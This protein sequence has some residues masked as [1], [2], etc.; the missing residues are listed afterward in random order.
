M[1]AGGP[2]LFELLLWYVTFLFSVTLHEAAHAWAAMKGGDLTA[3]RGGQV[4]LDPTPHVRR[5]PFGM[6]ILPVASLLINGW[7]FGFASAPYDPYWAEAYPKRASLM[8][9]AG[10]LANWLLVLVSACFI[11]L[12]I[13][14]FGVFESPSTIS[15]YSGLVVAASQGIWE[16]VAMLL[17]M[18]F[19]LNLILAVLNLIP[20]PPLDGSSVLQLFLSERAAEKWRDFL[21]RPGLSIIGLLCAWYIFGPIFKVVFDLSLLVLYP[22]ARYS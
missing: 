17:S 14:G 16:P 2:D 9:L 6:L 10:P 3:Y 11:W 19:T 1:F 22:W 8:A 15:D 5:E 12:G 20:F 7:P 21:R 18:M 13:F 4:S